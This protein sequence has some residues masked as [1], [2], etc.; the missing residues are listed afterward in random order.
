MPINPAA[1]R[2]RRDLAAAAILVGSGLLFFGLYAPRAGLHLDDHGFHDAFS[3]YDWAGLWKGTVRYV[4]GRNLYIPLFFALHKACAGS[5]AAMH[6]FGLFLDLL[7]PLLVLALA[8]RIGASRGAALAAAGLFLVWPNHGETH[9]WT[10]AIIM[11]LL[12]TTLVLGAFLA[13]GRTSLPRAPRLLLAASLYAVAL[14]DY[15]QVFFLW[16]PLLAY[17]RWAD[18]GLKPRRLAAAAGGFLFLDA[19]HF[20]ARMLSPYAS[21]GRP[22]PRTDVILLSIKHALTQT[23]APMRRAPVLADFPGGWPTALL[24]AG[25]AAAVWIFLCAR[26]WNDDGK[27]R[28]AGRLALFG[29]SWWLFAYAPNFLWYISPRHNYLPSIGTAL[30]AA[31]LAARL[32]RS[33]RARPLLAA[34]GAAFFA[35]GGLCAW[36]DG[37]AW[38]AS[39][40]LHT[41]YANEAIPALPAGAN[42]VYLLGAP[43]DMRTAPGFFHPEE[44]LYIQS[45]ETGKLPDSG[46]NALA[47]NRLGFFSRVQVDLYGAAAA[48][49]FVPLS[50]A[51]LFALRGDGHFERIC[52]LRLSTP[53]LAPRE[54]AVGARDCP[55]R[56]GLEAPVALIESRAETSRAPAP[57]SATLASASLAAGPGATFDLTLTWRM[58]RSPAADFAAHPILL[59]ATGRELFRSAY[60][61]SSREHE[62]SW[63]LFNDALPPSRWRAGQTIVEK[64]RLRRSKPW[65][66][67]PTRLR[68]TPFERRDGTT[69]IPLA[70]QEVPLKTP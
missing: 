59:G 38:A 2:P 47:A 18:P 30:V 53:W 9:W 22:V 25:A 19:A 50:S 8:R 26:S 28:V 51:T 52:A 6:L 58:G 65:A 14:F 20:A 35:L 33:N 56:L 62:I 24:L 61:A 5:A 46:D 15:D 45:R 49:R 41:R 31:A 12:T 10:S 57:D 17:A 68:L 1:P 4:P 60:A 67:P 37:S 34:A 66:E 39:T 11:N 64:H 63:P 43:K 42:A 32:S 48:P 21:G 13:A 36:S 69:W 40:A 54:L 29:G 7:N 27:D 16:I 70:V 3:H 44:H 23:V 55:G